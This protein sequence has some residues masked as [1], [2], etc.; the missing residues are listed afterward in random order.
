MSGVE[1]LTRPRASGNLPPVME[2]PQGMDARYD[3]DYFLRGKATGKSL[4]ENYRWLPDL[5][6]PMAERITE[7]LG[8]EIDDS[9][10]DFGCARGYVVRALLELDFENVRGLDV[11]EWA[12]KNCDPKVKGKLSN[13]W[14]DQVDWIIAKDVL[15]HVPLNE[16]GGIL[17]RMAAVARKGVFIVVPLSSDMSMPY[18]VRDYEEDVTHVI[19]WPLTAWVSELHAAFDHTWEISARYRVVGIKD[20][21]SQWQRGNGFLTVRRIQV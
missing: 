15:E 3:A 2:N 1:T 7:H 11:S 14:P 4:Y 17:E 5:T 19:R 18:I 12:L 9:I 20:N 8:I 10:L 21:Y 6:I 13:T 16:L